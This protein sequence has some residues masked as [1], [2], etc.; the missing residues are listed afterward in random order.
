LA[1]EKV[2]ILF[3]PAGRRGKVEAGKSVLQAA[4]EL[5][6]VIE[7]VCGGKH[8]CGKCR[9]LVEEGFFEGGSFASKRENLSPFLKEE[10]K[11]I[12]EKEREA[13]YRLACAAEVQGDVLVYLP[14]ESRGKQQVIRKE[15]RELAIELNPG[16]KAYYVELPPPSLKEPL[17]DFE[18][19]QRALKNAFFL[20]ALSI[21]SPALQ[22]LPLKLR[23][24]TWKVT[25]FVWMD[26]EVLDVQPGRAKDF[27]GLAVDI[28]TTTVAAY[29]C[30]L[31][32]G[33]V[34]AADSMMNPQVVY[35]ED[36]MTRI[37]YSMMN[38]GS[39]VKRLKE[40]ITGGLNALIQSLVKSAEIAS[41]DIL[42]VV[43]VGNTAMHHFFLGID[44]QHLGLSPFSPAIH[45]S[46]DIKARDLGLNIHP[47]ANVHILP[48]EAGFVGADN[49]GVL[50]SEAPY[51]K[52][53][54]ELI[55]DIGTN[56]ELVLG[57]NK[58][59]IS[60]SCATGPALE[61]AHLRFGMRAAPGAIERVRID[62]KTLEV[63]YKIIGLEKW[64][65][66]ST[67]SEIQARG[68]CGSGVI[69]ALA[70]MFK[71]GVLE[72]SGRFNGS[73]VSPRLR[74]AQK[75]YE[76]VIA[77]GEETAIGQ[78]ITV[79]VSDIRS[80]QLAKG[81]LYAGSK[82]MM[83]ILGVGRVDKVILAGAFGSS[84][85]RERAMVLGMFPDCELENVVSVG[86]AAGDG[87]RMALLS[88]QKRAEANRVAREVEYV[89]LTTYP[90]FTEEFV[91][92]LDFPHRRDAFPHL[93]GILRPR[94]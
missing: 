38:P 54:V 23:A 19:L 20:Q 25:A 4:Q 33:Q 78:D 58:R 60:C 50:I 86:N 72:K 84:I 22:T 49:V 27:Y 16:V 44:P 51:D 89:E 56:G 93:E 85:D 94:A 64:S 14:E 31:R 5:G 36:V 45:H 28:G 52:E 79:S 65:H 42:E 48:I 12:G 3:Q 75:G 47:A 83:S 35:G 15:A 91:D 39:G 76:F 41:G 88:R 34:K 74:K 77:R 63:T 13:G 90:K 2:T 61:G 1:K 7:S 69:E 40:E 9:V 53:E 30:N 62:P 24:G 29:L 57:N 82:I 55:I 43:V 32:N 87:A 68:I 66:E 26:K 18:R 67:P 10:S 37:T 6:V 70:E 8:T 81:A 46:L 71:A 92:S 21:D 80:V 11:F 73:L 17:G 59:L